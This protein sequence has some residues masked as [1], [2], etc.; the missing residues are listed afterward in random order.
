MGIQYSVDCLTY[1]DLANL[2]ANGNPACD[3]QLRVTKN[4]QIYLSENI[5]GAE[6]IDNLQFRFETFDAYSNFVGPDAAQ[7]RRWINR[8]FIATKKHWLDKDTS[9][10][11]QY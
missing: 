4:G 8:L 9:Y 6:Q 1:M 3:N 10:V 2:I 7:D 5:V 11:D